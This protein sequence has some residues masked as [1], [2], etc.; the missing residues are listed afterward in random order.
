MVLLG[1]SPT[2]FL[3]EVHFFFSGLPA[4]P[5]YRP[6]VR[7]SN[8]DAPLQKACA[9]TPVYTAVDGRLLTAVYVGLQIHNGTVWVPI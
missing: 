6:P 7:H 4:G 1:T 9:R 5:T 3:G 8:P 2:S